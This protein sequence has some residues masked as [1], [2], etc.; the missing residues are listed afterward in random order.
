M[1]DETPRIERSEERLVARTAPVLKGRVRV[2][3]RVSEVPASIEVDVS[4][5]EVSLE[6][7]PADRLLAPGES[8]VA[9][10]DGTTVVLVTE[11]RLEV[12]K[13]PWVV[14]EIHLS[15]REVTERRSV[16]DMV[17]HETF[18]I[19]TDGDVHINSNPRARK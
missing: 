6:R 14:E 11:E 19:Q 7:H 3:R 16:T 4:R 9:N 18:D 1:A 13:V 2:E 8:T 12:R 10:R 5:H 17:R 15:R